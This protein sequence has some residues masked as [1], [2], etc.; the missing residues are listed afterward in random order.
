MQTMDHP[1]CQKTITV[2]RLIEEVDQALNGRLIPLLELDFDQT[3]NDVLIMVNG[4][5]IFYLEGFDTRL[6]D[7]DEV[8]F[9]PMVFGG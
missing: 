4:T 1:I 8:A 6:R 7:K 5:S 3:P 9:I 2:K